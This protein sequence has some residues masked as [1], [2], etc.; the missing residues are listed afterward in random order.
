MTDGASRPSYEELVA[1]NAALRQRV[2]ELEQRIVE[3][4]AALKAALEQLEAARRAGKRQ[5]APF[6]KGPP[7]P[8][9][10]PSGRKAGHPPAHREKPRQV[11]RTLD[12]KLPHATCLKCRGELVDQTIQVQYQVEIPPVKPVVTQFNVE[13]ARCASCGARFQGRHPDPSRPRMPWERPPSRLGRGPWAWPRNSSTGWGCPIA[14]S[15]T[16]WTRRWA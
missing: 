10:K 12:V 13:A 9:P 2:A 5:A 1:D 4:E 8:N 3:L 14:K 16:S 15:A 7:K 6:S 11:D